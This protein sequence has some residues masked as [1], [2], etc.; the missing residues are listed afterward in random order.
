[1]E[2]VSTETGER[3]LIEPERVLT[4][5]NV[6]LA[7]LGGEPMKNYSVNRKFWRVGDLLAVDVRESHPLL[8]R[9]EPYEVWEQFGVEKCKLSAHRLNYSGRDW[10]F[11]PLPD[12]CGADGDRSL[13]MEVVLRK[14]QKCGDFHNAGWYNGPKLTETPPLRRKEDV[15]LLCLDAD[16]AHGLDLS[17]VTHIFLLEAIND[18]SLL[19]QV[20]SRAHRLGATGPVSIETINTFYKCSDG[21]QEQVASAMSWNHQLSGSDNNNENNQLTMINTNRKAALTKVVCHHCYRQ[22]DS[23]ADAEEHEQNL[24]PR[25]PENAFVADKYHLSSAYKEIRPPLPMASSSIRN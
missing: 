5:R 19:E 6:P 7:R 4:P 24:C 14:W 17:F 18:A 9:R 12:N 10:F 21:F 20:T 23:Y 11:G 16:L 3:F 15:F 1:M 25:N 8:P 22:F 13:E 2:V